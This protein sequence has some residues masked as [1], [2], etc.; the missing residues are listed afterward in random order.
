MYCSRVAHSSVRPSVRPSVHLFYN[1]TIFLNRINRFWCQLAQLVKAWNDK[2]WGSWGQMSRGGSRK[3]RFGGLAEVSFSPPPLVLMVFFLVLYKFVSLQTLSI[4]LEYFP[5][6]L[7]H[8]FSHKNI[9]CSPVNMT[10]QLCDRAKIWLVAELLW[11]FDTIDATYPP[12]KLHGGVIVHF[13][14]RRRRKFLACYYVFS[15]FFRLRWRRCMKCGATVTD[16]VI[17]RDRPA[18][19]AQ[20]SLPVR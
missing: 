20:S 8:T 9:W 6:K 17:D 14:W 4:I 5:I 7:S 18:A 2:L 3:A 13:Q 10:Q 1:Y 11:P 16:R 19:A 15:C 12:V